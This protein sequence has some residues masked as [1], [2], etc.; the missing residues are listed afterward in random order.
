MI[1]SNYGSPDPSISHIYISVNNTELLYL[2][3]FLCF[4]THTIYRPMYRSGIANHGQ[5]YDRLFEF[6]QVSSATI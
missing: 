2:F 1:V 3:Y 6:F 4:M 5:R